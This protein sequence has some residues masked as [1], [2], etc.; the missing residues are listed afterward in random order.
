MEPPSLSPAEERGATVKQACCFDGES[1]LSYHSPGVNREGSLLPCPVSQ[2][3]RK[4]TAK[5][6]KK[7]LVDD[8]GRSMQ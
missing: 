7:N 8:D 4:A 2:R 3:E 1:K 5:A 6:T